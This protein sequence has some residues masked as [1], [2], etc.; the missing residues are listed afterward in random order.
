MKNWNGQNEDRLCAFLL[1]VAIILLPI[2]HIH[3]GWNEHTRFKPR[4]NRIAFQLDLASWTLSSERT[5]LTYKWYYHSSSINKYCAST[6]NARWERASWCVVRASYTHAYNTHIYAENQTAN[7]SLGKVLWCHR[8]IHTMLC[9]CPS[10]NFKPQ[11]HA[12]PM[13]LYVMRSIWAQHP[14]TRSDQR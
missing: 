6:A 10:N 14:N 2:L 13:S 5:C 4:K 8:F 3:M 12:C 11:S 9:S 1:V 7:K